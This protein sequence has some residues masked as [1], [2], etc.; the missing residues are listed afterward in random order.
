MACAP[1]RC[2][3]PPNSVFTRRPVSDATLPI[4]WEMTPME[5]PITAAAIPASRARSVRLFKSRSSSQAGHTTMLK[6]AI[7]K[8]RGVRLAMKDCVV[9]AKTRSKHVFQCRQHRLF[10][11]GGSQRSVARRPLTSGILGGAM[12]HHAELVHRCKHVGFAGIGRR[13]RADQPGVLH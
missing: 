4:A 6:V 10:L 11:H 9:H 3:L 8:A 2:R 12:D 1:R 7:P 13:S 5:F